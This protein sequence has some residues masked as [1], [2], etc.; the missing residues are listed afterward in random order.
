MAITNSRW[1]VSSVI[2]SPHCSVRKW[3]TVCKVDQSERITV[4]DRLSVDS[5]VVVAVTFCGILGVRSTIFDDD[6]DGLSVD[7]WEIAA[8]TFCGILGGRSTVSDDDQD[9]SGDDSLGM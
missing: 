8:V 1:T 6:H 4:H 9:G 5:G 2:S 3:T 7:G